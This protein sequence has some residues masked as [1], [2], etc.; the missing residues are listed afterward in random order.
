MSDFETDTSF[1]NKQV[2]E[3][4]IQPKEE[5]KRAEMDRNDQLNIIKQL[6]SDHF[7]EGE[8]WYLISAVWYHQWQQ[9]CSSSRYGHIEVTDI[10]NETNPGPI[11]NSSIIYNENTLMS[12]LELN[13]QVMAVPAQAWNYLTEW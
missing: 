8:V 1:S 13:N 3:K 10:D 7:K 12:D 6:Q 4:N 9:Y 2:D 11:D 5:G